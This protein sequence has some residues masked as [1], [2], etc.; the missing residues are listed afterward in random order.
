YVVDCLLQEMD[1]SSGKVIYEWN[2]AHHVNTSESMKSPNSGFGDGSSGAP[3]DYFHCTSV[4]KDA[5][6]NYVLS[7]GHTSTIYFVQ[8][9]RN[10]GDILRRLGGNLSDIQLRGFNFSYQHDVRI[11]NHND[12]Q[13]S[14]SIF[15][16]AW[17]GASN[18]TTASTGILAFVD[19]K[20]NTSTLIQSYSAP[21][22]GL[23]S[24]DYGNMQVLSNGNV[25]IGWGAM[26]F[27]SE[28]TPNGRCVLHAQ[29]G[30]YDPNPLQS[31]NW[32]VQSTRVVRGPWSSKPP[33]FDLLAPANQTHAIALVGYGDSRNQTQTTYYASW[34]GAT[35]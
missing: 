2:A 22:G 23:H 4:D 21:N 13:Y 3:F 6:G 12:S 25:F 11:V 14:I 29:F 34:N 19:T 33:F 16:N 28:F 7:A 30:Q 9:D 10:Q 27:F 17:D 1:L 31:R 32:T 26:P 5:S 8:G 20:A 24:A 35:N 18:P 15:N